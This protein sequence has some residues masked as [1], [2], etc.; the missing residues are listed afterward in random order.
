MKVAG[1]LLV[2]LAVAAAACVLASCGSSNDAGGLTKARFRV[3]ANAICE[4]GNRQVEAAAAN[5]FPRGEEQAA[6]RQRQHFVL[7]VVAP[8]IEG[9]IEAIKKLAAPEGDDGTVE[10]VMS[11]L[12]AALRRLRQSPTAAGSEEPLTKANKFATAAGI[13]S[14]GGA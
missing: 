8:N 9:E 4:R 10:V 2:A 7:S 1:R 5:R 11:E 3:S 14:C 6:P 12:E 13:P